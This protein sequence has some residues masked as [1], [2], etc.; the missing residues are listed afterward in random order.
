MIEIT[1]VKNRTWSMLGTRRTFGAALEEMS[2]DWDRLFVMSGDAKGSS[3]LDRF[4]NKYPRRYL[5]G[6]IAEQNMVCVASGLASEGKIVF[7]TALSPFA[8]GRC[9][10]QIRVH[11]GMMRHN[12]KLVGIGSGI[13]LGSQ[14]NTHY[15]LDDASLMCTLPNMTVICPADCAEVAKATEAAYY[16]DGPVY[17]RLC[18]ESNT[19]VINTEDYDF[20]IGKAIKLREGEEVSIFASGTMVSQS[21][22]AAELLAGAGISVSVTN[23]HT[24]KPL[25]TNAV[26]NALGA[27]LIV[28]AEE[29]FIH[30]GL[31]SVVLRHLS[32]KAIHPPMLSLGIDDIFPTVGSYSCILDQLGLSAEKIAASIRSRLKREII[33]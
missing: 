28:T 17:L 31:S 33:K 32:A 18:G 15:G 24:I 2:A 11:L 27:K 3:G 12:V 20:R 14:G 19:P 25:D 30:G 23:M 1:K 10:D 7:I 26:D 8:T 9:Y 4:A 16:H 29:G 5:S 6:G 22:K 13:G 21:L